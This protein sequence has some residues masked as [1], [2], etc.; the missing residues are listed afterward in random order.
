MFA[1]VPVVSII[2]SLF[3]ALVPTKHIAKTNPRDA[4][5]L[6]KR[7]DINRV[8]KQINTGG[9]A[10]GNEAGP[11]DKSYEKYR[12]REGDVYHTLSRVAKNMMTKNEEALTENHEERDKRT[13]AC[14]D[15]VQRRRSSRFTY[16]STFNKDI[17]IDETCTDYRD[18]LACRNMYRMACNNWK[19]KRNRFFTATEDSIRKMKSEVDDMII[20]RSENRLKREESV[21]NMSSYYK[22]C[23]EYMLNHNNDKKRTDSRSNTTSSQN[24]MRKWIGN[25]INDLDAIRLKYEG[26]TIWI[27]HAFAYMLERGIRLPFRALFREIPYNQV[28]RHDIKNNN[29]TIIIEIS[30]DGI[31]EDMEISTV[32]KDVETIFG[33]KRKDKT[34][35]EEKTLVDVFTESLVIQNYLYQSVR[36]ASIIQEEEEQGILGMYQTMEIED[37]QT[38]MTEVD[39]SAIF[40]R[41]TMI[42]LSKNP[43]FLVDC[44][45][46]ME[47]LNRAVLSWSSESWLSYMYTCSMLTIIES[48]PPVISY[49]AKD[50]Y[51]GEAAIRETCYVYSRYLFPITYCEKMKSLDISHDKSVEEAR[52]LFEKIKQTY[53]DIAMDN[54]TENIGNDLWCELEE[55]EIEELVHHLKS[56]DVSVGE[57][58]PAESERLL[59][60]SSITHYVPLLQAE[61][62]K[63][64]LLDDLSLP[65]QTV[66][67]ISQKAYRLYRPSMRIRRKVLGIIGGPSVYRGNREEIQTSTHSIAHKQFDVATEVNLWYDRVNHRIVIPRPVLMAPNF[68]PLYDLESKLALFGYQVAH[69]I[70]HSTESI[71]IN[72]R[73]MKEKRC[74][75]DL[76]RKYFTTYQ[77]Y[78]NKGSK[79]PDQEHPAYTFYENRADVVGLSVSLS[80]LIREKGD[81]LYEENGKSVLEFFMAYSQLWC[82]GDDSEL[83]R[84]SRENQ[85]RVRYCKRKEETVEEEDCVDVL[86]RVDPHSIPSDRVNKVMSLL[87]SPMKTLFRSVFHCDA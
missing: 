73:R 12:V 27:S 80:V 26:D 63:D 64:L 34:P 19:S 59:S 77:T 3:V 31:F 39:I 6:E 57:C 71:L 33:V 4:I 68:S 66:R 60:H 13:L 40:D 83:S 7:E 41:G 37:L 48:M 9:P 54:S 76:F 10:L 82:S 69:E 25:I 20:N 75:S 65:E 47:H 44:V 50:A 45:E 17:A 15:S 85:E 53:I 16:P 35:L 46:Y 8:S 72:R 29:R 36:T 21:D 52:L 55:E 70:A 81:S 24:S 28:R 42:D 5:L 79:Y 58:M 32:L 22:I 84:V 38:I 43:L 86:S 61:K 23:R 2:V 11:K 30:P 14:N 56:L 74:V 1:V 78:D 51:E 49:E 18:G 87:P 62:S 67:T